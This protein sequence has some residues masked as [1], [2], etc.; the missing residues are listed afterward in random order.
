[1][2]RIETGR[3]TECEHC[4]RMHPMYATGTI[5]FNAFF[6]IWERDLLHMAKQESGW[7]S[8]AKHLGFKDAKIDATWTHPDE[9][10]RIPYQRVSGEYLIK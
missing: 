1:M 9:G 6:Y 10:R 5:C 3:V 7:R 4:G 2:A 8:L